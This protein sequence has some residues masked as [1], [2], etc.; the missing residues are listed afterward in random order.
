MS[1]VYFISICCARTA[2][3]C[4]FLLLTGTPLP[5]RSSILCFLPLC[6]AVTC[7]LDIVLL[8]VWFLAVMFLH[9]QTK[10]ETYFYTDTDLISGLVIRA[11]W[12]VTMVSLNLPIHF[13]G[14]TTKVL[15]SLFKTQGVLHFS[16]THWSRWSGWREDVQR[17]EF[18]TLLLRPGFTTWALHQVMFRFYKHFGER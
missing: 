15:I 10:S 7:C 1:S 18:L 9:H 3:P 16:I 5:S 2:L 17:S 11:R 6:F 14:S 13:N 12:E 4:V 8:S